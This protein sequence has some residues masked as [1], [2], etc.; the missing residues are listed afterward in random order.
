LNKN[1]IRRLD[2]DSG[3]NKKSWLIDYPRYIKELGTEII[4]SADVFQAKINYFLK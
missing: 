2:L 1:K 4:I 3:I